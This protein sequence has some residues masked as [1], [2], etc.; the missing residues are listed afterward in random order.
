LI[1]EVPCR[2]PAKPR[3]YR[4]ATRSGWGRV[5][6]W[7]FSRFRRMAAMTRA[8][9]WGVAALAS[10]EVAVRV[11]AEPAGG[12]AR[13]PSVTNGRNASPMAMRSAL[14]RPVILNPGYPSYSDHVPA[15]APPTPGKR[16]RS[17][18]RYKM[19]SHPSPR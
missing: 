17:H 6:P 16:R 12:S 11:R 7:H 2:Q 19:L 5:A 8:A 13:I 14:F 3:Y 9:R 4:P 10:E 1:G 15:S 18:F